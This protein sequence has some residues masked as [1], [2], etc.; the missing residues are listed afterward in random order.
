[1]VLT[2]KILTFQQ[3]LNAAVPSNVGGRFMVRVK[4]GD[5]ESQLTPAQKRELVRWKKLEPGYLHVTKTQSYF[6]DRTQQKM[7]IKTRD[8]REVGDARLRDVPLTDLRLQLE[9]SL[10]ALTPSQKQEINTYRT[11]EQGYL[12]VDGKGGYFLSNAG[13]RM[14]IVLADAKKR[15]GASETSASKTQKQ[16]T[17]SQP[18]AKHA[19]GCDAYANLVSTYHA[20]FAPP[21]WTVHGCADILKQYGHR[22]CVLYP[23]YAG[24]IPSPDVKRLATEREPVNIAM[25]RFY[26]AAKLQRVFGY[27]QGA[28]EA[29]SRNG[30]HLPPQIGVACVTPMRYDGQKR[31]VAVVSIIAMAFDTD[32]QPDHKLF[33]ENGT[34]L[35]D[36]LLRAMVQAYVL[37]FKAATVLGRGTL[38]TSPI[39]DGAFRPPGYGAQEFVDEFVKPAIRKA[40]EHF[41]KIRTEWAQYPDFVVPNFITDDRW[42]KNLDDKLF[43][44]AW[45]PYSMLGNGNARDNSADGFW[46]R[47]TAIA[48]LGWPTSNASIKY[49]PAPVAK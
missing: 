11:L 4:V 19:G 37:A 48:L 27:K 23:E 17:P 45:D 40:N 9:A 25:R 31:V 15:S 10:H 2:L 21:Q 33:I 44:N 32:A 13:E 18:A 35:K 46:G 29:L 39:G 36:N 49:V 22:A 6:L 5:T 20:G 24:A 34:L 42:T 12:H 7:H 47:S 1:M 16:A 28:Y 3:K 38:C 41:P 8:G 14:P 30:T 43:V 26:D